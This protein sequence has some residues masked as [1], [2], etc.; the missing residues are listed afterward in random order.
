MSFIVPA[1]ELPPSALP[2]PGNGSKPVVT[3]PMLCHG[4]F[5][6]KHFPALATDGHCP[7]RPLKLGSS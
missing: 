2:A 4:L 7:S 1:G 6:I 5:L 3:A